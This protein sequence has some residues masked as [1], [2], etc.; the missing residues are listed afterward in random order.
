LF[1]QEKEKLEF[2]KKLYQSCYE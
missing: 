1:S 2:D